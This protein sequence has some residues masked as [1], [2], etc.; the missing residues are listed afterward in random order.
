MGSEKEEGRRKEEVGDNFYLLTA[1][2]PTAYGHPS[3][4]NI[5]QFFFPTAGTAVLQSSQMT[6]W[7]PA[8]VRYQVLV[9]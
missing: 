1:Y 3:R 8:L 4:P 2:P 6:G 9:A 5:L 7:K